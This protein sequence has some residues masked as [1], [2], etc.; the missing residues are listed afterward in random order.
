MKPET[1]IKE[2]LGDTVVFRSY[3]IAL[4]VQIRERLDRLIELFEGGIQFEMVDAIFEVADE[5]EG[6]SEIGTTD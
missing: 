1:T 3:N 2:R 4:L 6:R 5:E